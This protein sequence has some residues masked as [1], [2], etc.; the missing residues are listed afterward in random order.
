MFHRF[1]WIWFY[2]TAFSEHENIAKNSLNTRLF[3][4]CGIF[5]RFYMKFVENA[6]L[7]TF[8]NLHYNLLGQALRERDLVFFRG[9]QL[10][11]PFHT[12]W[13]KDSGETVAVSF[14]SSQLK[15]IKLE[16][17]PIL[18]NPSHPVHFR[19]VFKIKINL[20]FYFRTSLRYFKRFYEAFKAFIK[21]FEV[22][23]RSSKIKILSYFFSSSG[24]GARKVNFLIK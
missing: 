14:P 1:D 13:K 2:S 17:Y 11:N 10:A 24:I 18:L 23:Q 12:I 5:F 19:K 9:V 6:I 8:F 7:E 4:W 3:S 21:P 20:N 22:P 16:I 15:Y